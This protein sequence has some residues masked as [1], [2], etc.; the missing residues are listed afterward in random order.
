MTLS[1]IKRIFS[2]SNVNETD[3]NGNDILSTNKTKE[4]IDRHLTLKLYPAEGQPCACVTTWEVDICRKNISKCKVTHRSNNKILK[5]FKANI[6]IK[7]NLLTIWGTKQ[8]DKN[9]KENF[10][11]QLH[12]VSNDYHNDKIKLEGVLGKKQNNAKD[13][14]E[15]THHV[16]IV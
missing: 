10:E 9:L 11:L 16:L 1:Q 5:Q 4:L 6:L 2:Q 14:F 12:V 8:N 15:P 13:N 3:E 7:N